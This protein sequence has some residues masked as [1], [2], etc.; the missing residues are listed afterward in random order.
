VTEWS[1]L[2]KGYR[3]E[4]GLKQDALAY[5]LGVDQTTV[6]RW[7]RGKDIPSLAM[8]KRLRDMMW[9]REDSALE[10][11]ARLVRFNPGRATLLMP[12]TK[13]I[14]VSEPTAR[15]Y[16]SAPSA[17]RGDLY[18]KFVGDDFYERQMVPVGDAGIYNGEVAR[19]ESLN[20]M[21]LEDGTKRFTHSSI[22]PVHCAS[23]VFVC[24]LMQEVSAKEAAHLPKMKVYRY[25]ELVD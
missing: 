15:R 8:Q 19:V 23:G 16:K 9:Q 18:R 4:N 12:G 14:E 24:S 13:V 10:A 7:E 20:R 6:S 2:V 11:V 5:L 3:R 1:V 17:M 22:V 21:S 25:D